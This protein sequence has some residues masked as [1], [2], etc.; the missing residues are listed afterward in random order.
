MSSEPDNRNRYKAVHKIRAA[1]PLGGRTHS[2]IVAVREKTD[3]TVHFDLSRAV[4][5]GAKHS[6]G[7]GSEAGASV[8]GGEGPTVR[9]ALEGNP[10]DRNMD[11]AEPNFNPYEGAKYRLADEELSALATKLTET[12]S[13]I[14]KRR[15]SHLITDATS[16]KAGLLSLVP[17]RALFSELGR[18]LTSAQSY[19]RL[20]EGMD[21]ERSA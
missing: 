1:V 21:A 19:M 10:V 17:S 18:G 16:G 15:L 20:K 12:L 4:D 14:D 9:L 13:K 11:Y 7:A 8:S 2:L 3:G 6:R 5:D